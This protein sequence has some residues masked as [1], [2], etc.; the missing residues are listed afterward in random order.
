MMENNQEIYK[1]L[2]EQYSDKELADSLMI[3]EDLTEK[4]GNKSRKNL[5]N[6]D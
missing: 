2:R 4:E 3:P 6:G 1:K 5:S